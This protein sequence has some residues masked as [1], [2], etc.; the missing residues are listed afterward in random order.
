MCLLSQ[1]TPPEIRLLLFLR[2]ARRPSAAQRP[3]RFLYRAAHALF[4]GCRG[5]GSRSA[6]GGGAMMLG[7]S[8]HDMGGAP[9]VTVGAAHRRG[10]QPLPARALIHEAARDVE[11][12]HIE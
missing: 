9:H 1:A 8:H 3:S 10:P 6:L 5:L 12:V 4:C 7:N 2:L 11:F